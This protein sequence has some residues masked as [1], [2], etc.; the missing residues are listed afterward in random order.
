MFAPVVLFSTIALTAPA[1]ALAPLK[2]PVIP[3]RD[4][5]VDE[6]ALTVR[7]PPVSL[8]V[9]VRLVALAS[10][11]QACVVFCPTLIRTLAPSD[12]PAPMDSEPLIRLTPVLL[13]ASMS[14]LCASIAPLWA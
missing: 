6:P 4:R 11:S 13:C 1:T 10:P 12:P 3:S 5:F 8:A 2:L 14:R 9:V 7:S